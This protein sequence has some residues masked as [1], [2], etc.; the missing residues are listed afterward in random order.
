M[1]NYKCMTLARDGSVLCMHTRGHA[2]ECV[3]E[4]VRVCVCV[5]ACVRACVCQIY[6]LHWVTTQAWACF[7]LHASS[8]G[9]QLM[10]VCVCVCVCVCARA[11]VGG[12]QGGCVG[13]CE[14]ERGALFFLRKQDNL[15]FHLLTLTAV[16]RFAQYRNRT[17]K[18]TGT[19]REENQ[20]RHLH[21]VTNWRFQTRL[22][23]N[24][25]F[26]I[27]YAS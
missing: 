14:R 10:C 11:C 13:V 12:C 19:H 9:C 20:F 7:G 22:H 25:H 26:R 15:T 5:C 18:R 23:Q 1:C 3:C 27:Q 2:C 17:R 16:R 21:F 8:E 24:Y 4:C 6:I